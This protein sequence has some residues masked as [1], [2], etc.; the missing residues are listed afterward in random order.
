MQDHISHPDFY[1]SLPLQTGFEELADGSAYRPLPDDWFVGTADLVGSTRLIAEGRYKVVNTVGAAVIS[2]QINAAGGERFPFVFGGDGASFALPSAHQERARDALARV[3]GWARS[4]F[5]IEMRG[6]IVPLA[7]IRAAG[8]DVFV[9]RHRPSPGVDYAMFS[10]GGV[11]WAEREM[12]A[13]RFRIEAAPE[14]AWPNLEGLSCRWTP[15]RA[16]NGTIL[17]LLAIPRPD[18]DPGAVA[19]V[20]RDVVALTSGLERGGHPVPAVG[21]GYE[22]PPI[23]LALEAHATRAG[24]SLLWRKLQLVGETLFAW[25]LFRTGISVGGFDPKHYVETTSANADF[26]KFDDGLKMTLDCD[27]E[28]R[29]RLEA[30]LRQAAE[31]GLL[32]YGL[33]EQDEAIMTCIVPSVTSDDHVHFVD[34]AAGGYTTAAMAIKGGT[35]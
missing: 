9:A 3:I 19:K 17:S 31:A 34:G 18:A 1:G 22:W 32:S 2:A 5:G 21:P 4:E 29:E 10:G 30:K 14:G 7:E 24:G 12:K 28:T 35:A 13:G 15:M 27:A 16:R 20:M 33:Y 26:R 6:A 23:G 8:H 11:A 25:F